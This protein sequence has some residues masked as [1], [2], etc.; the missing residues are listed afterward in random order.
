MELFLF[1]VFAL[2][3]ILSSLGVVFFKSPIRSA[4]SLIISFF[5]MGAIYIILNAEFV[6]LMQVLVYAGAIMVLFLFIIMLLDIKHPIKE[7]VL[8]KNNF[9]LIISLCLIFIVIVFTVANAAY[10]AKFMKGLKGISWMFIN[11]SNTKAIGEV[12]FNKYLLPFE[13]TSLLLL[14]AAI[15]IIVLGKKKQIKD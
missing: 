11:N 7:T 5:S 13:V 15:G 10:N 1:I 8:Y 14:V 3:C 6:A 9:F 4:L 12:L 2:I